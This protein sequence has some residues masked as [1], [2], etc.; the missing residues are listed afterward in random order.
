MSERMSLYREAIDAGWS[1][2][3]AR[4]YAG[5]PPADSPV[6]TKLAPGTSRK[7]K[8]AVQVAKLSVAPAHF[9]PPV[10]G[11]RN[12]MPQNALAE[13]RAMRARGEAGMLWVG[14]GRGAVFAG[15]VVTSLPPSMR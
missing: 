1:I 4:T 3:E 12:A 13:L 7:A 11:G 5:L 15:W 10:E 14:S 8:P 6:K 9:I 2:D